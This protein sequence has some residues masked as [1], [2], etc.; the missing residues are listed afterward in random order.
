VPSKKKKETYF[1]PSFVDFWIINR[2]KK[3]NSV[4]LVIM[5]EDYAKERNV[6]K[7]SALE[8]LKDT[9]NS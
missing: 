6:S 2:L 7:R 8:S 1:S 4:S 9:L 5:A 3:E